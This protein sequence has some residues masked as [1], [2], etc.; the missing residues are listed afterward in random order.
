MALEVGLAGGVVGSGGGV[1]ECAEDG[2]AVDDDAA[3]G[4]EVDDHVGPEPVAVDVGGGGLFGEIAAVGHA[5][6]FDEFSERDFAPLSADV[7]AGEGGDELGGLGGEC[8]LG[9]GHDADL[10]AEFG[11]RAGALGFHFGETFLVGAEHFFEG[12]EERAD[13]GFAFVEG[14][15]GFG[16]EGFEFGFGHLDEGEVGFFEGVAGDGSEGLGEFFVGVV[17]E[18]A[19]VADVLVG[20]GELCGEG[21][22]AGVGVGELRAGEGEFGVLFG[23]MEAVGVEVGGEGG[24][25]LFGEGEGGLKGGE[26]GFGFAVGVEVGEGRAEGGGEGGDDGGGEKVHG[27]NVANG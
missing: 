14:S 24:G 19:L 2:F 25:A 5:G 22:G 20:G 3:V 26:G 10:L 27:V 6:E 18:F 4:G 23:G 12:F 15:G 17:E 16:G 8:G 7:G 1:E 11:V 13:L 9:S 21:G